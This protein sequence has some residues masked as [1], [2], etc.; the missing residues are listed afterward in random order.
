MRSRKH[1]NIKEE[2]PLDGLYIVCDALDE[3]V[4]DSKM[5]CRWNSAKEAQSLQLQRRGVILI[6][7]DRLLLFTRLFF[8]E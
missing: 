5:T 4:S 6:S 8:D 3:L 7:L 2:L 1:S